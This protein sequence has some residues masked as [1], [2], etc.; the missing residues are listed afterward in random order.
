ML[1]TGIVVTYNTQALFERAYTSVRRF[2]PDLPLII[3]DGSDTADPC[4][5]YVQSLKGGANM[6]YQLG[7]NIG[8]GRG[9]HYGLERCPTAA[10]LCF[11]SDI[12]MLRSPLAEMERLL[13]PDAYGV[14]WIYAIGHDGY[15]FGTP[16]RGHTVPVPYMHPYFMLLSVRQYFSYAPFVHHGA[17]AY[18]AMVDLHKRG[19]SGKLRAFAGLTG[20]TS[21]EGINWH[22]TPSEYVRHDFGGTRMNNR[23]NGKKEIIGQW[24]K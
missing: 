24:E 23:A 21:G 1:T 16:D 12:E 3:I 4:Y 18:K 13:T 9:L 5:H 2:H 15:D 17:P 22:G 19:H 6:V 7:H 20:H 8:H 11:D 10:A 14:G